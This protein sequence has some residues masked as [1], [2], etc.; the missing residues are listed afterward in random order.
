MP[1]FLSSRQGRETSGSDNESG[2]R[3]LKIKLGR[4]QSQGTLPNNTR[5]SEKMSN[6]RNGSGNGNGQVT[7]CVFLILKYKD[8][9]FPC[10][11]AGKNLERVISRPIVSCVAFCAYLTNHTN[12]LNTTKKRRS[13]ISSY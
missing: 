4:K 7:V 5:Q 9:L 8:P 11:T 10:K 6:V 1:S 12:S 3:W 13:E 2:F